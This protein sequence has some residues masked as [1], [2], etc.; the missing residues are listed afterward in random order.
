MY[1]VKIRESMMIAH[2]LKHPF[3]GPAQNVHGATFVVDVTF[4]SET[5]DEHNVVIDIGLAHQIVK[6]IIKPLDYQNLDDL[7]I[8]DGK[9]TTTEFVAK[10][11]FDEVTSKTASFFKGKIA[12]SIKENPNAWAGFEA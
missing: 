4:K 8:F 10:Y 3:F 12:V 1:F 7:A 6:E 11:I 5:V 9:L 2:S